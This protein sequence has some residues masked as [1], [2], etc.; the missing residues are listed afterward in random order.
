MPQAT[1]KRAV[2]NHSSVW[3]WSIVL[4]GACLAITTGCASSKVCCPS[5]SFV[6]NE[7]TSR[8]TSGVSGLPPRKTVLPPDADLVNGV[9]EDEAVATALSNNPAFQATLTQLKA[10]CGDQIQASLLMNPS[11]TT[12]IPVSVKQWEWIVYVPI[13]AFVLR[14][15]R[16]A[17]A[18]SESQRVAHQLVQNGLNLVRDVRVAHTDL[19]LAVEQW[20]LAREAVNIRDSVADLTQKRLD[21]GDISELEAMTARIDA[22]NARANAAF[23]E[24]NIVVAS[25]DSP[26]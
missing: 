26:S 2:S 11:F 18:E 8:T 22:L 7:I 14:P 5:S 12:F 9:S 6:A 10:A 23:M 17:V 13:E 19:S 1:R 16:I 4:H 21:R 20:Q 15:Q 24:Q 3:R 25:A